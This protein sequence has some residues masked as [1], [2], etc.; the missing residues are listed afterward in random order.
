MLPLVSS[1]L[2]FITMLVGSP[3]RLLRHGLIQGSWVRQRGASSSK[4]GR[5]GSSLEAWALGANPPTARSC[6]QLGKLFCFRNAPSTASMLTCYPCSLQ[7]VTPCPDLGWDLLQTD[8][9]IPKLL[10]SRWAS[11]LATESSNQTENW[12]PVCS[13][14]DWVSPWRVLASYKFGFFC[15][16][17][18]DDN[19]VQNHTFLKNFV[20]STNT[21][22]LPF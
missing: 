4:S 8:E 11:V 21:C 22:F 15:D 20:R 5:C 16:W 19:K 3:S 2:P 7:V 6:L 13:C 1:A 18:C 9:K 14:Y 10:S 12:N 17:G